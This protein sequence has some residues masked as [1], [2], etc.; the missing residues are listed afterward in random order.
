M[1][2]VCAVVRLNEPQVVQR[3]H[4]MFPRGTPF[5]CAWA[6]MTQSNTHDDEYLRL[7]DVQATLVA[8]AHEVKPVPL[9][10]TF[11]DGGVT[12]VMKPDRRRDSGTVLPYRERRAVRR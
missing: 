4:N 6:A 2:T 12:F 9:G 1:L 10:A 5:A 7:P 8:L 3:S 11:G